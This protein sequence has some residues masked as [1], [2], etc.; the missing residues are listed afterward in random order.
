MLMHHRF[1]DR[2]MMMRYLGI[3]VGHLHPATFPTEV[4]AI[5]ANPDELY[6]PM[7]K[8]KAVIP[9]AEDVVCDDEIEED[10]EEEHD[11]T[12]LFDGDGY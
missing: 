10:V 7:N 1:V 9:S 11:D 5:V 6:I 2:D 3:G 8:R 12:S 4:D